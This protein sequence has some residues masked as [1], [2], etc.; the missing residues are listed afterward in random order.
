MLSHQH[1]GCCED[2]L[3]SV[4]AW[5]NPLVMGYLENIEA[6]QFG[7]I[8]STMQQHRVAVQPLSSAVTH[9]ESGLGALCAIAGFALHGAEGGILGGLVGYFLGKTIQSMLWTL[10]GDSVT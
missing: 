10:F 8:H 9:L 6:S 3:V 4:E 7:Q 1:V 5:G 2:I